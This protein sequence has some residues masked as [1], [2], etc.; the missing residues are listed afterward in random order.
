MKH[1]VSFSSGL[2]SAITAERV[3]QKYGEVT[4]IFMDTLI[5]DDDN[6]RFLNDMN[7]RWSELYGNK[8]IVLK[9]G[10]TPYQVGSDE[11]IIPN[12]KIAPCTFRLKI[13]I[14]T[15]YL[16]RINDDI[17]IYI[18]YDW[19]EVHRIEPTRKNYEEKGWNVD[20]PLLWKPIEYRPYTQVCREDWN[21]EPPRMYSL[22]YTHANCGGICVKQG[23]GDW[24]RTLINFPERYEYVEK[25]ELS[26]RQK[27][28]DYA[29][30]RYQTME[31]R[32]PLTLQELRTKYQNN[33]QVNFFELD[34]QSTCISCGIGDVLF[35]NK[36]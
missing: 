22:G 12:N 29:I 33:L 27:L 25:W 35:D 16:K 32:K 23:Q 7:A 11:H 28:G 1:I 2:S 15:N 26:M 17:T 8:I 21:I 30:L 36:Y 4:I 14:F 19:T 13:E 5:E 6:Y 9:E 10:R 3:Q 18:G 34:Q 31:G 24:L 20:F